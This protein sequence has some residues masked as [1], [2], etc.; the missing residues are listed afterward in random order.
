MRRFGWDRWLI[1]GV[2]IAAAAGTA[3]VGH[4]EMQ[5]SWLQAGF[6][7]K[8]GEKLTYQVESGPSELIKYPTQGPYNE[9]LGYTEIPKA[10]KSLTGS[11][12]R[13]EQQARTSPELAGFVEYGGFAVFR[14]KTR[15]GLTLKDRNGSLLYAA[16]YPERVYDDF[17]LRPVDGRQYPAVHREPRVAGP[18]LPMRNPAVEWDR[19]A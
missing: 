4:Q 12:Y 2:L 1:G 10:V 3:W 8:Y 5:T 14:E 19:F 9:R 13:I 7:T 16:R 18:D 15:A 17:Q 11:G 6:L